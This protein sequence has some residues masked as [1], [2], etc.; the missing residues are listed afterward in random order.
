MMTAEIMQ[1]FADF[2]NKQIDA[3]ISNICN[4]LVSIKQKQTIWQFVI[5]KTID[6]NFV[7]VLSL[8]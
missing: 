1:S 2:A 6:V 4:V 7:S 8:I 3:W 5:V